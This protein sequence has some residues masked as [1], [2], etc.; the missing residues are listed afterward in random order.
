MHA[1]TKQMAV[2]TLEVVDRTNIDTVSDNI[3]KLP[4]HLRVQNIAK[5]NTI[6]SLKAYLW[7]WNGAQNK[8][9]TTPNATYVKRKISVSDDIY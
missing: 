1:T 5:T 2:P 9:L 6:Q 4:I 7:I 3:C 8:A